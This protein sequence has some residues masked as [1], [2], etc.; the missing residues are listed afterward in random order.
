[1]INIYEI[2]NMIRKQTIIL[3]SFI[4]KN[5]VNCKQ[6]DIFRCQNRLPYLYIFSSSTKFIS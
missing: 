3:L 6:K 5:F 4:K 2:F 1:M